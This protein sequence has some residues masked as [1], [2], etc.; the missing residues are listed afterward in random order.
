MN[1]HHKYVLTGHA[2]SSH[3][4]PEFP[5]LNRIA[6]LPPTFNNQ[7]NGISHSSGHFPVTTSNFQPLQL[8]QSQQSSVNT[9]YNSSFN[10]SQYYGLNNS[11][12]NF[13]NHF[14]ADY[15]QRA[16]ASLP[17][18]QQPSNTAPHINHATWGVTPPVTSMPLGAAWSM[19]Q[20]GKNQ[21]VKASPAARSLRN[22]RVVMPDGVVASQ[23]PELVI[24][25]S[26]IAVEGD[27][28]DVV[29]ETAENVGS[30]SKPVSL[31]YL[32]PCLFV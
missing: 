25:K 29:E 8:F 15:Y 21:M 1:L 14:G 4:Q 7:A 26:N 6:S 19:Q 22:V 9:P 16:L 17:S 18:L 13:N 24:E 10:T 11:Q 20:N 32:N 23:T 5:V 31:S 28:S 2:S 27:K 3:S 12:S 30:L